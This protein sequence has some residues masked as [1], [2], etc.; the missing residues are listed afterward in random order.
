[1]DPS[2]TYGPESALQFKCNKQQHSLVY[3]RG[4]C[5]RSRISQLRQQR[6]VQVKQCRNAGLS[7][8]FEE[9]L[10]GIVSRGHA[11]ADGNVRQRQGYKRLRGQPCAYSREAR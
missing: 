2:A 5:T 8:H 3:V 4:N 10:F 11:R 9:K 1:M 6:Q 7:H